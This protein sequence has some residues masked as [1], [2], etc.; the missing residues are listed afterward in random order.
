LIR[1]LVLPGR[2]GGSFEIIDFLAEEISASTAINIM[3]QYRPC[4]KADQHPQIN[5]Y[6][7]AEEITEVRQYALKK[8]L[9]LIT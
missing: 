1:H 7:I 8:G 6:P 2:L 5:R 3:A 4:Y 9:T